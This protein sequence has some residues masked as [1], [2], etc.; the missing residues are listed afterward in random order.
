MLSYTFPMKRLQW[1]VLAEQSHCCLIGTINL[2]AQSQVTADFETNPDP[3]KM[4]ANPIKHHHENYIGNCLKH[5]TMPGLN[6]SAKR[7]GRKIKKQNNTGHVFLLPAVVIQNHGNNKSRRL[8][9]PSL[10]HAYPRRVTWAVSAPPG[11]LSPHRTSPAS[12]GMLYMRMQTGLG[13]ASTGVFVLKQYF[14]LYRAL[15]Q[16][17]TFK[18]P[19]NL[20]PGWFVFF[21]AD[22]KKNLQI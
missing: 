7:W 21:K 15:T 8:Q 9:P 19:V 6:S 22:V 10:S 3:I 16:E 11:F 2:G 13:N 1:G 17:A 18:H 4:S 5:P 12:T 20:K 14:E